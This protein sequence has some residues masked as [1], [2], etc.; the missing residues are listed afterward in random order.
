MKSSQ[1]RKGEG[2]SKD[3]GTGLKYSARPEV[4]EARGSQ[5]GGQGAGVV[6]VGK[7]T[8]VAQSRPLR[9]GAEVPPAPA[10][11]RFVLAN[12]TAPLPIC[13]PGAGLAGGISGSAGAWP[14]LW[15]QPTARRPR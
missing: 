9:E 3:F 5:T 12:G 6:T 10:A 13:G 1:A 7:D 15:Y 8:G 11:P 4:G 14:D 2:G